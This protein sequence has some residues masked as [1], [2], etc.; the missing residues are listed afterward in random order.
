VSSVDGAAPYLRNDLAL[1]DIAIVS[2]AG[3]AKASNTYMITGDSWQRILVATLPLVT[4]AIAGNRLVALQVF[5][6]SGNLVYS[7]PAVATQPASSAWI[8]TWAA[9]VNVEYQAAT[10]QVMPLPE[11]ILPAGWQLSIGIGN[12]QAGDQ[13]NFPVQLYVLKI[14]TGPS[15]EYENRSTVAQYPTP[16]II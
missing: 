7:I 10:S 12:V 14:P 1:A 5:D 8:Y 11:L 9:S 6:S 15:L 13:F 4:S 3:A 16:I 2:L